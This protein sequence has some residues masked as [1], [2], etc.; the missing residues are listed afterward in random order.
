MSIFS[1]NLRKYR[2]KTGK[3]AKEFAKEINVLYSTYANYEQGRSE[4]KIDTLI[5]IAD[6]LNISIDK[7]LGYIPKTAPNEYEYYKQWL[8]STNQIEID[9]SGDLIHIFF[10][11]LDTKKFV[12]GAVEETYHITVGKKENFIAMAKHI[13]D[14]VT[15]QREA[16][17]MLD[18]ADNFL[19]IIDMALKR[20]SIK[21]R[22]KDE[23]MEIINSINIIDVKSNR[24]YD[25]NKY[26]EDYLESTKTKKSPPSEAG[27]EIEK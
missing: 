7:L 14:C 17:G 2:E 19:F 27:E 6:C 23:F 1:D 16:I 9:D 25:L 20:N 26:V 24:I 15:T 5:K 18:V 11:N 21:E 3:Q 10:K 8:L 12:V 4:P 13:E 22:L